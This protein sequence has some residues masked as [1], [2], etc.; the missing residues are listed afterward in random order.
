MSILLQD[1]LHSLPP[2][3]PFLYGL[4]LLPPHPHLIVAG[5]ARQIADWAVQCSSNRSSPLAA[6]LD[7]Y[8]GLFQLA[9]KVS[10]LTLYD[11][12]AL[13]AKKGDLLYPL[14]RI[15][16][17][18]C[19]RES[20]AREAADAGVEYNAEED[21]WTICGHPDLAVLNHWVFCELFHH[22]VD[23]TIIGASRAASSDDPGILEPL[24][25]ETR[26]RFIAYCVPDRTNQ[27]RKD[28][29]QVNEFQLLDQ[30]EMWQSDTFKTREKIIV[31]FWRTG[32]ISEPDPS[33]YSV[34]PIR[35]ITK[36]K[37]FLKIAFDL[38]GASMIMLIPG[39]MHEF[40]ELLEEIKASVTRM[41][42]QDLGPGAG[43]D[44]DETYWYGMVGDAMNWNC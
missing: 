25:H 32:E 15:V 8:D 2:I 27:Y 17:H 28:Y 11:V 38:G 24:S 35:H 37:L 1:L 5:T 23:R 19:G 39:R 6:L 13:H 29:K 36:L 16:E 34:W 21:V 20:H 30:N 40:K 9:M 22:H 31:N 14:T 3:F 43:D 12:R 10:R 41:E 4:P 33:E 42:L 44:F 18:D 26:Q 7:G